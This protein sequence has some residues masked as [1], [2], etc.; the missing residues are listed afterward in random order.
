MASS[1][2]AGV[3]VSRPHTRKHIVGIIA[4]ADL[5]SNCLQDIAP[6]TSTSIPDVPDLTKVVYSASGVSVFI[7]ESG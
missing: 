7:V 1:F 3:G 4:E 2:R 5:L 6:D